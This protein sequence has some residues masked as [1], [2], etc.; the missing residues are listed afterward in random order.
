MGTTVVRYQPKPEHADENQKLVEAVFAELEATQPDGLSY[1]TFRL[2]DGTFVHVAHIEG[3]GN[4]LNDV[5]AFGA[6]AKDIQNRCEPGNGPNPQQATV[7][8]AYRFPAGPT[9]S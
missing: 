6:F 3:S 1:T 9:D 7:V 2:A 4:P 5:A 8:G